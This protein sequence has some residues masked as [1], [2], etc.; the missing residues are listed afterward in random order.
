MTAAPTAPAQS[1]AKRALSGHAAIGLLASALLYI[2][3][4][5]GAIAVIHD[6]WQ[7]WEE[8]NIPEY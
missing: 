5:T 3:A 8:P 7:R 1:L 2:V 4:L 6:R